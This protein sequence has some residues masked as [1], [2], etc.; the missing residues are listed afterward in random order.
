MSGTPPASGRKV[1][2]VLFD[3][4]GTLA[5]SYPAI[6]ASVNH[7]RGLYGLPPLEVAEVTKYVG[8]GAEKLLHDTCPA[9]DVA[10]NVAAYRKHHP[11]VLYSGTQLLPGAADMLATLLGR[12]YR[13]ALCSNK[14]LPFT[15]ELLRYL[16][17][18]PRFEVVMGP[19]LVA[20]PKPAPDMLVAALERL[21]L[22]PEEAVYVGDMTV[23]IETARGAGVPVWVI[24]TGS[25]DLGK[26]QSAK[27]DRLLTS[28]EEV[29]ALLP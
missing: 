9:G 4:D 8:R 13:L 19:E 26:L 23:D 16:G 28:L 6:T 14:P 5:D 21:R 10:A 15:T 20:R 27:P 7:V 11:S 24:P 3:L 17:I 29:V 12:G 22:L 1:R 18:A 2:A 25:D